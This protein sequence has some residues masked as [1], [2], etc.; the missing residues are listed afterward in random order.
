VKEARLTFFLSLRIKCLENVREKQME[1]NR[2]KEAE[3]NEQTS[4]AKESK[5]VGR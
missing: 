2:K 4:R 3:R 1:R 5:K